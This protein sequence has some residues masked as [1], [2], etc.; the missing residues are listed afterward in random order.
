MFLAREQTGIFELEKNKIGL[1]VLKLNDFKPFLF[2]HTIN[3]LSQVF[4]VYEESN[5][6]YD[7]LIMSN[8]ILAITI[9]LMMRVM[10]GTTNKVI[11]R[12]PEPKI[13]FV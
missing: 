5:K 7:K 13:L 11:L 2:S 12:S 4:K 9:G 1:F 8:K 10:H 3:S 6:S